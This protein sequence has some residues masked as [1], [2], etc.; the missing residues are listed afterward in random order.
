MGDCITPL[1]WDELWLKEGFATFL[2]YKTLMNSKFFIS[3][4]PEAK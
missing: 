3:E 1:F 4:F 2:G